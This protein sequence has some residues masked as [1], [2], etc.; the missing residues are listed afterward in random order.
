MQSLRTLELNKLAAAL[1][2]PLPFIFLSHAIRFSRQTA[3]GKGLWGSHAK[4]SKVAEDAR[5]LP[6][7]PIA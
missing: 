6:H 3:A 4:P 1:F 2:L 5:H 7:Q